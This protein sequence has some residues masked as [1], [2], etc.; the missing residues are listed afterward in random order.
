[1]SSVNG[2]FKVLL[3]ALLAAGFMVSCAAQ[4]GEFAFRKNMEDGYH[5]AVSRPEFSTT[6]KVKWVYVL[7][8][9][10]KD[11]ALGVIVL[12]K[13]L[14][15]VEINARMETMTPRN[16]VIYGEINDYEEGDYRIIITEKNKKLDEIE[17]IIYQD[18]DDLTYR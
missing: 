8:K 2:T 1:M 13:E 11:R 7:Q 17:F 6:D 4:R 10:K 18:K 9:L 12:K 5:K 16:R 3:P 15:W 14:V